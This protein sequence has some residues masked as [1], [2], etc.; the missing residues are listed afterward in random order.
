MDSFFS[1]TVRRAEK[2]TESGRM[3]LAL[4]ASHPVQYYAP[5]FRHIAAEGVAL[6]VFYLWDFGV[7]ETRDPG[8]G[9]SFVWDVPLLDGYEHEFVPNTSSD[10]GTH[11]PGGLRNPEL[12]ERVRAWNP[13]AVLLMGYTWQ[14]MRDLILHRDHGSTPLLLRGDSHDLA[15][16]RGP[17]TWLSR[18]AARWIFKRFSGFLSCGQANA[19]YFLN[20]G[21]SRNRIFRCPHAVDMGR[22]ERTGEVA[23]K[24]R[25]L[26]T[27]WNVPHDHRVI[28]FAGKFEEK[29]R[30]LDLLQ[31]FQTLSPENATLVFVGSGMGEDVLRSAA[32]EDPRIR[33]VP[34]A[35]QSTMPAVYAAADLFVLPSFGPAETWGLAVQ[36]ALACGTPVLVSSHVGCHPD[37]VRN[38][39]NGRVFRAGSLTDLQDA[40]ADALLPGQL[41]KWQGHTRSSLDPFTYAEATRGLKACLESVR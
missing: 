32:G 25:Q 16:P 10:P 17:R 26:R 8:F 3:K 12:G 4:I 33:V 40:L 22:F 11:H 29:K 13:D 39:R 2:K 5:W 23:A 7:K 34:F 28:L 37:L 38:G 6:R 35:N 9:Q 20:R 30:P 14:S 18:Q 31:A 27:E 19:D 1:E 24:A 15:R 21:A 36:E 41:E